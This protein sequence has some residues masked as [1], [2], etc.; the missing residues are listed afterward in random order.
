MINEKNDEFV[1]LALP[2]KSGELAGQ[3]DSC[4]V[5]KAEALLDYVVL[6]KSKFE[7][8]RIRNSQLSG[9]IAVNGSVKR[10]ISHQQLFI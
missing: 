3:S 5:Q 8:F 1:K 6:L 4:P 2:Y 9:I 7:G 10:M